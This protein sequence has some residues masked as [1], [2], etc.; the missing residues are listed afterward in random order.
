MTIRIS[1][2]I[3]L[4]FSLLIPVP[5]SAATL[6]EKLANLLQK[7]WKK[8]SR[9]QGTIQVTL[10]WN[11]RLTPA[12]PCDWPVQKGA[13]LCYYAYAYTLDPR[14]ADGERI[15][16]AWGK[17]TVAPSVEGKPEF[18][19]LLK[20]V[21]ELGIQGVRPLRKE[22]IEIIKTADSVEQTLVKWMSSGEKIVNS[23][24]KSFKDF[25]CL[26]IQNNGVIAQE[27]QKFH[28][29]FFGG[30]GCGKKG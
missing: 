13:M 29:D 22:E 11:G 20:E 9:P 25:Y 14:L 6:K 27:I 8:I 30:L 12:F 10:F 18:K 5:S 4:F 2:F 7:E 24:L 1:I 3:L 28:P 16:Q 15:A 21:K 17:V 19:I 26:W 23:D